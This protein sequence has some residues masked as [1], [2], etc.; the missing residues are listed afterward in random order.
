MKNLIRP[1]GFIA[2]TAIIALLIAFWLLLADWLLKTA[3]EQG[4]SAAVGAK[5]E[6]DTAALSFSPF[7]LTLTN[8]QVTDPDNPMQNLVQLAQVDAHVDFL[9]M[10][11][12][13]VI[14][15][16]LNAVGV[17]LNTARTT[18]GA[19]PLAPKATE[20]VVT[21]EAPGVDLSGLQN[22]LPS[23]D[24]ILAR[25][26]LSTLALSDTFKQSV[27]KNSADVSESLDALP[28][29]A[30]WQQYQQRIDELTSGKI[31]SVEDLKQRKEALQELKNSIRRDKEALSTAKES[32]KTAKTILGDQFS[33]LKN[34]PARDLAEIKSKYSLGSENVANI[35]GLLF[36]E[37]TQAWI[38]KIQ[39]WVGQ[40]QKLSKGSTE[41]EPPPPARGEGRFIQFVTQENLPEVLVRKAKLSI[42][43]TVG[44]IEVTLDDVT[45]QPEILGRPMRLSAIA[46]NLTNIGQLRADGIFNHVDPKQS[47]D[48]LTWTVERW[49]LDN[50]KLSDNPKMAISMAQA[51]SQINGE[52]NL[53]DGM[54]MG[55]VTSSFAQVD[56]QGEGENSGSMIK[57]LKGIDQFTIDVGIN[58]TPLSPR[59]KLHSD[60]DEKL[61]DSFSRKL[62]ERQ[63]ALEKGLKTR[64]EKQVEE[65]A[66][67][68]K[69][70]LSDINKREE[71][72]K[73]RLALSEK[74]LAAQVKEAVEVKREEAKDKMKDK[75][76][77]KL[78]GLKF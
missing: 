39:P 60:L 18:S 37:Q 5:V 21:Q 73:Q 62:K 69:Q 61:K 38:E 16:D 14:V 7:G 33:Q 1:T 59:F 20:E 72:I 24:E 4:G 12:G 43:T 74:M 71:T 35:S 44:D 26:P 11:M 8:I 22:K 3:V 66:A 64:L 50:L 56:W 15:E 78:K 77:D 2:F 58:G 34:A 42:T 31:T 57:I 19:L 40:I 70:G 27:D 36:G 51:D 47:N 32:I 68:Y 46:N 41:S 9:K 54:L 65:V 13:Q 52:L 48:K 17:R 45:H 29:E 67:P 53:S 49:Q 63:A 28:D 25:E 30:V 75:L 6:L 76:K 55:Q 23:V 10:L